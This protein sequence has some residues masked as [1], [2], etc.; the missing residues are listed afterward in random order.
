MHQRLDSSAPVEVYSENKRVLEELLQSDELDL[1][2]SL[3]T[4][5][6]LLLVNPHSECE[7]YIIQTTP[8][9]RIEFYGVR[10]EVFVIKVISKNSGEMVDAIAISNEPFPIGPDD[11]E[12]K[13]YYK[14]LSQTRNLS[15]FEVFGH[16]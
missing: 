14:K 13:K 9:E 12:F 5:Y 4:E 6:K 8:E 3:D 10:D 1:Q 2:D 11:S 16:N 15:G 7:E